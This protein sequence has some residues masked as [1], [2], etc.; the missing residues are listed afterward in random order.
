M[1]KWCMT[2]IF[3]SSVESENRPTSPRLTVNNTLSSFNPPPRGI[4]VTLNP[5]GGSNRPYKKTHVYDS[6]P[7]LVNFFLFSTLQ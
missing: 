3:V 1:C 7:A 6:F 4:G 2:N 5:K